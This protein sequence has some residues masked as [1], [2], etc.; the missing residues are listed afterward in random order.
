MDLLG[1]FAS[2]DRL[3]ATHRELWQPAP[4]CFP[5]LSWSGQYPDLH[6]RLLSLSDAELDVLENNIDALFDFLIPFLPFLHE[7]RAAIHLPRLDSTLAIAEREAC[8]IP[9]RK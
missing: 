8:D 4:F 6:A 1:R 5:Q 2:L 7:L 3:L 9:G